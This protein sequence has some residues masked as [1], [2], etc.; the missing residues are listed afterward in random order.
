[1]TITEWDEVH[2]DTTKPIKYWHNKNCLGSGIFSSIHQ[3][4]LRYGRPI[5][6][7]RILLKP[8]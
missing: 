7:S 1:M 2:A 6:S 4:C 5:L 3:R 8:A